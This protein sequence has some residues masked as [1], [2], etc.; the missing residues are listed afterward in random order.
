M[1][2][3][4][5]QCPQA[6]SLCSVCRV[7]PSLQRDAKIVLGGGVA[8]IRRAPPK[9][10][11]H[12][13][14]DAYAFTVFIT[15]GENKHTEAAAGCSAVLRKCVSLQRVLGNSEASGK[16]AG[17]RALAVHASKF[18]ACCSQAKRSGVVTR[19]ARSALDEESGECASLRTSIRIYDSEAA[20]ASGQY[21]SVGISE[22]CSQLVR[23]RVE[24]SDGHEAAGGAVA[25]GGGAQQFA[26]QVQQHMCRV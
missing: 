26:V 4:S 9:R 21:V 14:I 18:S 5:S 13:H 17:E 12:F 2:L 3:S 6:N 7:V 1:A 11:C 15:H 22:L 20:A 8:L 25:G 23:A 16:A 24:S 10:D 19:Q